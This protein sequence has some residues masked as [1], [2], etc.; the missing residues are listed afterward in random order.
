MAAWSQP[1][2]ESG[3]S[4]EEDKSSLYETVRLDADHHVQLVSTSASTKRIVAAGPGTGKT[5]L[6][7][8]ILTGKKKALVLTF[9][10]ALVEDLHIQL[11]QCANVR[12]LH[13]YARSVIA[14]HGMTPLVYND[15][16]KVIERDA[17]L[18]GIVNRAYASKIRNLAE[19]AELQFYF[20]RKNYYGT[21]FSHDDLIYAAVEYLDGH[22]ADI[23]VYEQILIDEFQDFNPLEVAL[24]DLLATK[25]PILVAGDDDQSLYGF[26]D[27]THK[28]LRDRFADGGDYESFTLPYCFRCPEVVVDSV[29]DILDFAKS[30]G[31][32][33]ERVEKDYKY[34]ANEKKDAISTRF[35]SVVHVTRNENAIC[36]YI[37]SELKKIVVDETENFDVLVISPYSAS[38][39]RVRLLNQFRKKGFVNV[40]P[41][42]KLTVTPLLEGLSLIL[43][44]NQQHT[45]L[46]WRIVAE[47]LMPV[48][49]FKEVLKRSASSA[50]PFYKLL[51]GDLVKK[52]RGSVAMLRRLLGTGNPLSAAESET[53]WDFLGV[54]PVEVVDRTIVQDLASIEHASPFVGI[55][56]TPIKVTNVLRS[57]GLSAD[58]VFITHLDDRFFL[59]D[60]SSVTEKDVYNILV[61]LSR[62]KKKVYLMSMPN[63]KTTFINAIRDR[64]ASL[65]DL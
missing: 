13:S 44:T 33:D 46:G 39:F 16:S 11:P 55:R 47:A 6:F 10:N 50:E 5:H 48:A 34:A 52:V 14:S 59:E 62:A 58:Y 43:E 51:D 65:V 1:K 26:R 40:E 32:L 53:L 24:I 38:G 29:N 41:R 28:F 8:S 4:D 12:T 27:S 64:K 57:K 49:D 42:E 22:P 36:S 19:S 60:R 7:K 45:N 54:D 18:L 15:L 30:K 61:A 56:G 9:I 23:E 31:L 3:V 63:N 17:E 21:Y 20:E 2:R 25:S 37:E 35:P